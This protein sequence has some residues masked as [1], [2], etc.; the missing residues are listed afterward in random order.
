[1]RGI[2]AWEWR[3]GLSL[4]SLYTGYKCE[5]IIQAEMSTNSLLQVITRRVHG[6][7]NPK[8]GCYLVM[9]TSRSEHVTFSDLFSSIP[10]GK[11]R[12]DNVHQ[13]Y[14]L[15]L[16][17]NPDLIPWWQAWQMISWTASRLSLQQRQIWGIYRKRTDVSIVGNQ[18]I[19][20]MSL[21]FYN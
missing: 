11:H 2:L 19:S 20:K 14:I 8:N 16:Q 6:A 21:N 17:E 4:T 15:A 5:G 1:M 13:L 9:R 3:S 18:W 12:D 7:I 10:L